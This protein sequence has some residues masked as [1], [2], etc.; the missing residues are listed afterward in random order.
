MLTALLAVAV[1]AGSAAAQ[2]GQA[3][4]VFQ[5]E[6]VF[7]NDSGHLIVIGAFHNS[8]ERTGYGIEVEQLLVFRSQFASERPEDYT[9]V[10]GESFADPNLA[11]QRIGPGQTMRWAFNFGPVPGPPI[12]YWWVQ[13]RISYRW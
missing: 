13:S 11:A 9:F 7:H 6:E 8:G 10:A 2:V 3:N 1:S 4:I 5:P 12:V